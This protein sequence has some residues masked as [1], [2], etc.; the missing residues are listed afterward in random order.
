MLIAGSLLALLCGVANSAAAAI[1]K[2]ESVRAPGGAGLRLLAQLARRWWWLVAMGLSV[3]GW[4]SEAGG[5]ALAPVAV[6]ATLRSTGRGGL[7]LFGHRW[8]GEHFTRREL[9]GVA[10][11][12]VGGIVVALSAGGNGPPERPLA[13]AVEVELAAI[14]VA[15]TLLLRLS[16]RGVVAGAAV[17][18]LYA[19][20]GIYTKEIGDR[21][22]RLGAAAVPGLLASPGPWLMVAMSVWAISVT[23]RAFRRANAAS[24]SAA[25]TTVS[26]LGLIFASAVVYERRLAP[27]AL[28]VP[29]A[30]GLLLSV[31]G[32]GLLA[33]GSV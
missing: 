28:A 16:R 22:A 18:V 31:L 15:V 6:V 10:M 25:S 24:V 4:V 21:V 8:L 27:L 23:Q 14:V 2:R 12:A 17:G 5:L 33:V 26:G 9:I 19:A 11:L 29:F 3:V 1:E 30:V 13:N 7:V 20:T 32:A